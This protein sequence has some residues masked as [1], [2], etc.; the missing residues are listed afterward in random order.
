MGGR[1]R[2]K[3]KSQAAAP[4]PPPSTPVQRPRTLDPPERRPR[5][6][7]GI[8]FA[9][10]LGALVV[11]WWVQ[12]SR[13]DDTI[14][15]RPLNIIVVTADT[16]RADKLGSYGSQTVQTPHVDGLAAS[17]V[18]F[19]NAWSS[20]PLTLPSH[21]TLLTGTYPIAHGVRDNG[22][23]YLEPTQFTLAEA[24]KKEGY[25]TGAFVS[26]FVLDSHFGL[27]QGFDHYFDDFDARDDDGSALNSAH[28]R[29]DETLSRA[30]SWMG[31]PERTQPFFSWVHLYDTHVPYDPPEPFR[32]RYAQE[33]WGAYDGEVAYVDSLMG[34]LI[35]WLEEQ[36]LLDT[37]IIAFVADHGESLSDHGELT[38]GFFVY[39]ATMRVPLIVRTPHR[40]LHGRRVNELVRTIDLMPTLLELVGSNVPESVHGSSLVPVMSGRSDETAL[41]AFGESLLP[42]HYGWSPLSTVRTDDYHYVEAPRPELYDLRND[43]SERRNVVSQQAQTARDHHDILEALRDRYGRKRSE[44]R[45]R[46]ASDSETRERL[47]SLGYLGERSQAPD[48]IGAPA[49][50]KDKLELF[51]LI[52]EASA[53]SDEGRPVDAVAKLNRVIA[54][55]PAIPEAHNLLGRV[56]AGSHRYD[57]AVTAYREALALDPSYRP[58]IFNLALSFK[59]MG[60]TDEA[61]RGF[62]QVLEMD[63]NASQ[64]AFLLADIAL[65]GERFDEADRILDEVRYDERR[66][67][68]MVQYLRARGDIGRGEFQAGADK[69]RRAIELEP[70][71]PGAHYH[72]AVSLESGG[73][74]DGAESAY[75]GE[76]AL[77][78]DNAQA[79]FNLGR[80]LGARNRG[81][82]MVTHLE[83]A[84]EIE[85]GFAAGHLYLAN[86]YLEQGEMDRALRSAQ[87]GIELDPEPA[88]APFGHFILADLYER[89]GRSADAARELAL[90]QRLQA[91][92]R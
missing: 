75:R 25:D 54:Q 76:I 3:K 72:L 10:G 55:D 92:E 50:P 43:P 87:R 20:S 57:E 13:T 66:D 46:A 17:G 45:S 74:I 53:D 31:A 68:A 67:R 42:E 60:R 62:E 40:A 37:T 19:E 32:S 23:Y 16:L 47:R 90:A 15:A 30:L 69:L 27:D 61:A 82:D 26:A 22:G 2:K 64:A 8:A 34:D 29:G 18:L 71:L 86:A 65:S 63:E 85:P 79:H 84:I 80:L 14:E 83:K 35:A 77:D 81:G 11:W 73:D 41:V 70:D 39:D 33:P 48:A 24:L 58:A 28:R 88:L 9:V 52:R 56:L 21:A 1:R 6:L 51:K 38:H 89:M 49:D 36:E 44:D 91:G 7:W 59:E 78:A 4:P 5:A 12:S